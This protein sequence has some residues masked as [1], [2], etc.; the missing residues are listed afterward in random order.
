MLSEIS[1]YVS[2]LNPQQSMT[3]KMCYRERNAECTFNPVWINVGTQGQMSP[4][5]CPTLQQQCIQVHGEAF[6]QKSRLAPSLDTGPAMAVLEKGNSFIIGVSFN[7][8]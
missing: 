2:L 7:V 3:K 1:L 8:H 6:P 4:F 5:V